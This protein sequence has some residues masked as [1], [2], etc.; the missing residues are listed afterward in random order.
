MNQTLITTH[1]G[2]GTAQRAYQGVL[3]QTAAMFNSGLYTFEQSLE[4]AIMEL[5]Q[6]VLIP[7]SLTEVATGGAWR[8]C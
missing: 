8:V 2:V 4:R 3:N 1:Y 6:K 5:A 7:A